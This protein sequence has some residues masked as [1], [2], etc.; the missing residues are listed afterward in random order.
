MGAVS[1]WKLHLP[2]WVIQDGTLPDLVCGAAATFAIEF[3][4]P[5][6]TPAVGE[7]HA[8]LRDDNTYVIVAKVAWRAAR[9][10]MV[11][12][13]G[14][15]LMMG[16]F[17]MAALPTIGDTL[18]GRGPLAVSGVFSQSGSHPNG[19]PN[20]RYRWMVDRIQMQTAPWVEFEPRGFRRDLSKSGYRDLPR[21]SMWTDDK[22]SADYLIS[23]RLLGPVEGSR[24]GQ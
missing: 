21:T 7:P 9:A 24:R 19:M 3:E 23:C 13:V 18:G 5:F 1:L 2:S 6:F 8:D 14:H 15:L 17:P 10:D 20:V 16:A 4:A 11:I 22:G 12:D